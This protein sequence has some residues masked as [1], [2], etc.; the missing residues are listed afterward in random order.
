MQILAECYSSDGRHRWGE[1]E[2]AGDRNC[3]R[4]GSILII[5]AGEY[6]NKRFRVAE[7]FDTDENTKLKLFEALPSQ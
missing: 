1:I 7:I 4:L 6:E 2:L 3:F 5:S